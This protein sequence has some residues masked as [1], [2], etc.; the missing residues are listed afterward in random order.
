MA[1]LLTRRL[2]DLPIRGK[3]ACLLGILVANLAALI[4]VGVLGMSTLSSLRAYV[5]GEGVWAKAQKDAIIRLDR[6]ALTRDEGDYRSFLDSLSVP[7][8]DR[9]ARL[10]LERNPPDLR[11][12]AA[13]L[14]AGGI[15]AD[16]V[17]GVMRIFLRLRSVGPIARAIGYWTQGDD[18]LLEVQSAADQLHE[19]VRAGAPAADVRRRLREIDALN[20]RLTAL[21]NGFS[22][23]LGEASRWAQRALFEGMLAGTLLLGALSL[24]VSLLVTRSIS[25]GV[26]ALSEAAGRAARGDLSTR[27][28]AESADELGRLAEDFNRMIDGLSKID[29][30]KTDFVSTVSHELRTPL[31][32][33]LAPLESL[34]AQGLPPEQ[35][36]LV[37]TVHNNSVRLLQMVNGL[38]DFSRLEA[39]KVEARRE[40][41]D[42]SALTRAVVADFRPAAEAKGVSIVLSSLPL[43]GTVWMDRYLYERLLFNLLSNAVKFTPRGGTV[44]VLL[45]A[46]G[47]RLR[48][49]VEDTGIGISKEDQAQLFQKFR[50]VESSST[51]R[52]EGT[53]LGLALVKEFAALLDGTV[54]LHSAPE[55]GSA[56]V[57]ECKA[58]RADPSAQ[59]R[60]TARAPIRVPVPADAL[61]SDETPTG[62]DG[63][64]ARVL[65]AEDN[66]EMADYLAGLLRGLC[67]SRIARDGERALRLAREWAPDLVLTDVMM[68]VKDG[69]ALCREIKADPALSETP[70][71]LLT[72]LTD[73]AS[74]MRGW[75]AGADEYL[76]KPFHPNEVMTRV[77]T[78]LSAVEARKRAAREL[79]RKAAELERSNADLEHFAFAASHDLQEPLRKIT[80]FSQLLERHGEKTLDP[81]ARDMIRRM[82]GASERMQELVDGLLRFSRLAHK[83]EPPRPTE[84]GEACG[85]A[86]ANLEAALEESGARLE[87]G[88]L[89]RV[90]AD[91]AQLTAVFQNLLSNAVKFREPGRHPNVSVSAQRRDAGWEFA[92]RDDGIGFDMKDSDRVF[93]LFERLNPVHRYPG[94]GIGLA[95]CKKIVERHGGRIWAE[96]EPGKGSVFRFTLPAA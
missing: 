28:P 53:G 95:A 30:M 90:M 67:R 2:L 6:Y 58:P 3:L 1:T 39:G 61:E 21:E 43:E 71:V 65:I 25:S 34:L 89:P 23:S 87:M 70:V 62:G 79:A 32:L 83:S 94:T 41:L 31:T 63:L 84:A 54:S 8:S 18:V 19:A 96:S 85:R 77:R 33:A 78:L 48:L 49:T 26:G 93:A 64:S 4:V 5:G 15:H 74:M 36:K 7:L 13:G 57:V 29:R 14:T 38:L 73:R 50:Q 69:L 80:G 52:F 42:T 40:P 35:R 81:G 75:E 17:P 86:V 91:P 20:A 76:F 24:W 47:D 66:P 22:D 55:R 16:D 92:V 12:A 60:E 45:A 46:D 88:Q 10:A 37:E 27:V 44:R 68:P 51:R 56:F 59:K 72:A 9:R 82:A 11:A